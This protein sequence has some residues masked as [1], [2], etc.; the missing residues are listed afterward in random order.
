MTESAAAASL[1]VP[2]VDRAARLLALIESSAEP[3]AI[4]EAARVLDASKSSVRDVLETLRH[5]QL[6]ERDHVT[7][8]YRLGGRLIRLG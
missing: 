6:I 7:K 4:S 3:V 5:H 2:A 8:R 1:L